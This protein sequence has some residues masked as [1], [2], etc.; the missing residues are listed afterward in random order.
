VTIAILGIWLI[1]VAMSQCSRETRRWVFAVA[2]ILGWAQLGQKSF[3]PILALLLFEELLSRFA[4][5]R[6]LK[7]PFFPLVYAATLIALHRY[8][9]VPGIGFSYFALASAW[10]LSDMTFPGEGLR[11]RAVDLLSFP[12]AAVGPIASFRQH[13]DLPTIPPEAWRYGFI[14]LLK[15]H[16][17]ASLWR[18]AFSSPLWA[19]TGTPLDYL[20]FGLWNY[21][22]LY[23]EFSGTADLVL[24]TLL[25][26]GFDC[27]VNFKQPYLS[28]SITDFWRRWHVTLGA[29]IKRFVYIPLGGN[30][31]GIAML[32]VNLMLCMLFSG[33]WHGTGWNYLFWGGLQGILMCFERWT[34]WETGITS[35][36]SRTLAWATTQL[37]VILSWV[38]FFAPADTVPKVFRAII[39]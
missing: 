10:N 27:P 39:N 16:L 9:N 31:R 15:A 29:W 35:R 21:V 30:R 3:L 37:W 11:L 28:W 19:A 8:L 36:A 14:G 32:Y 4:P 18:Q 17:L 7:W 24:S 20:W 12:K 23:L 33:L 13:E 6:L 25:L 2:C 34:K 22:N 38:V 26:C 1:A 5:S